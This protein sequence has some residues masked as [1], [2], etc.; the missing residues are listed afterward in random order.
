[1]AALALLALAAAAALEEV[2]L[3]VGLDLAAALALAVAVPLVLRWLLGALPAAAPPWAVGKVLLT[4]FARQ[5]AVSLWASAGQR[6]SPGDQPLA[7]V[8]PC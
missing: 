1:M 8:E 3:E 6:P 7:V 4:L 5:V 2:G